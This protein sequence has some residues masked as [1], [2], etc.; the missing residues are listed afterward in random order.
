MYV[1]DTF[2]IQRWESIQN[3]LIHITTLPKYVDVIRKAIKFCFLS[4]LQLI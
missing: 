4:L 3:K 2:I 1:P